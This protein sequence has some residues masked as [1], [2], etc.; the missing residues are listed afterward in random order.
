MARPV[1][2][3]DEGRLAR[4]AVSGVA[5]ASGKG[6]SSPLTHACDD[7]HL[8]DH[9]PYHSHPRPRKR[10]KPGLN[11]FNSTALETTTGEVTITN[12]TRNVRIARSSV[13]RDFEMILQQERTG[14]SNRIVEER[15]VGTAS[16]RHQPYTPSKRRV[17]IKGKLPRS[18]PCAACVGRLGSIDDPIKACIDEY[19]GVLRLRQGGDKLPEA[20]E[21]SAV[22][23]ATYVANHWPL[24]DEN[25]DEVTPR[26]G[27]PDG[28]GVPRL[29]LSKYT[30]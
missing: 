10:F 18:V 20:A 2:N 27:V 29:C 11:G 6:T 23:L 17:V 8:T 25:R 26:A 14:N 1:A 9:G 21:A 16:S 28:Q 13:F 4:R 19:T 12:E 30:L 3:E 22:A 15:R 5:G 24:K 7:C